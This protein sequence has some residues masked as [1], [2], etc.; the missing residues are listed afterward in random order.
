MSDFDAGLQAAERFDTVEDFPDTSIDLQH[1]SG[2]KCVV[3]VFFIFAVIILL[4]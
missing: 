1:I 2:S 3:F 4:F